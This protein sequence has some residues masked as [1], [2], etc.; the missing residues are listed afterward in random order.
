MVGRGLQRRLDGLDAVDEHVPEQEEQ[1]S[2]RH[3]AQRRLQ[4][5]A[6]A[7][8]PPD[9]KTEEDREA[10]ERAEDEQL[11]RGHALVWVSFFGL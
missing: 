10:G 6:R 9:R 3:R 2:R 4:P 8:D 5:R 1:D 11:S 7:P